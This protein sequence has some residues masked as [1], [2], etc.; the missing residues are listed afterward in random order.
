MTNLKRIYIAVAKLQAT[1]NVEAGR[2]DGPFRVISRVRCLM[3]PFD[4]KG[5]VKSDPAKDTGHMIFYKL[6]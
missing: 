4:F 6:A 1:E 5:K 3:T 2:A